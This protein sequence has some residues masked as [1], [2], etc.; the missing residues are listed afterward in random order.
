LTI[1]ELAEEFRGKGINIEI[2]KQNLFA[3]ILFFSIIQAM[4]SDVSV[5][6]KEILERK[7]QYT[8]EIKQKRYHVYEIYFK[9][10]SKKNENEVLQNANE[11]HKLL[12]NGFDFISLAETI[13]QGNY[14]ESIGDLGWISLNNL[15][16]QM[17]SAVASLK[18]KEVSG[19][20]RTN[21]GIRIVFLD[22]IA[23][24]GRLGSDDAA[25]KY[26]KARVQ[27][28]GSLFTSKDAK[29]AVELINKLQK[30]KSAE[31]LK[32][33]CTGN[34]IDFEEKEERVQN[35]LMLN[36]LNA[37]N[38]KTITVEATDNEYCVDLY[39]TIGKNAPPIPEVQDEDIKNEL[40]DK[41]VS[42]VFSK[43]FKKWETMTYIDIDRGNVDKLM[44]ELK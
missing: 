17:A 36:I 19:I 37:A 23:E 21:T 33:I 34:K 43:T 11:V 35:P 24:P 30:A 5:I 25:Y 8:E 10:D 40:I 4:K 12:Q 14:R 29:Q 31:E 7:K 22:D 26:V 16:K 13:S 18:P 41:K 2:F 6:G 27:Y 42:D 9:I 20:I 44:Q 32:K 1:A 39:Y 28:R 15:D 3:K 38:G